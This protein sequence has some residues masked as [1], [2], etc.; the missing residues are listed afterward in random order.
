[1]LVKEGSKCKT[2][3]FDPKIGKAVSHTE[4]RDDD[5]YSLIET[6][7]GAEHL[8]ISTGRGNKV[9]DDTSAGMARGN[10]RGDTDMEICEFGSNTTNLCIVPMCIFF[11][12]FW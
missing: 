11:H 8:D 2:Y 5:C 3:A 7:Y 6:L 1:M 4:A 12:G 10:R 9:D